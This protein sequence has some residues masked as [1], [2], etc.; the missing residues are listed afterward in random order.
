MLRLFDFRCNLCSKV[1]EHIVTET[2]AIFCGCGN[3]M[4]KL[5]PI[6]SINMGVGAYGRYDETL[7]KHVGT[8][9]EWKEE[10]RKQGVTPKGDTPKVQGDAWV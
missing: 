1:E 8:N 5:P 4:E 10:M 9:K 6:I 2:E 7:D 3:R